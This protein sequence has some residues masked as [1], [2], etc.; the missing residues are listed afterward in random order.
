MRVRATVAYDGAPFRGF[1]VNDGVRTVAGDLTD[2]LGQVLQQPVTLTC[3]GRTDKGVHG[4]G[5]VVSFD[6]APPA[7]GG[8]TVDLDDLQLALNKMC[9][10]SI[11]V[12]GLRRAAADFDARFGATSRTYR[13][14]ILNRA[15]GDPLLAPTVW[16]VGP[17]LDVEAMQAAMAPLLGE[18]DFSSFCRKQKPAADGRVPPL[19]R[20][21]FRAD[22]IRP[23][24][25]ESADEPTNPDGP[26]L[27]DE[28]GATGLDSDLLQLEIQASSFCQQM[29]RSIAGLAVEVG[30]GRKRPADV[31]E[32]LASRDRSRAGQMAP[33]QGLILWA[34]G[35]GETGAD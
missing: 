24:P 33:P 20:R 7:G 25:V 31:A 10:P 34:V 13:Y 8:E 17:P 1:A 12:S 3:A 30:L 19:T 5:Q 26:K 35:Y 6:I 15:H 27:P 18:H 28:P 22:W 29:V 21:L 9:G 4:R 32:I 23:R 2:A 16:H 14:R 11:V